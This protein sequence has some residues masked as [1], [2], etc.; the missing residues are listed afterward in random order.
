M[1]AAVVATGLVFAEGA[2]N[3]KLFNDP[4]SVMLKKRMPCSTTAVACDTLPDLDAMA[5]AR[6]LQ[7]ENGVDRCL[8]QQYFSG[9]CEG[10][11]LDVGAL[12]GIQHSNTFALHKSMGWRGIN[13]EVDTDNYEQLAR[14][15]RD[16]LAN[17][18]AAAC[19]E[20]EPV[21]FA[22]SDDKSAGGI[23]EF[24]SEAHRA[25]HWPG[26]TEYNAIPIK[27]TPLQSILDQTVGTKPFYFDLAT[28][29]VEGAEASALFGIDFDRISFGV[30]IVE[31]SEDADTNRQIEEL[32]RAKGYN[33]S[34]GKGECDA[35]N[36]MW[37]VH[38]NFRGIYQKMK[39]R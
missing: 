3:I 39:S 16:D 31:K 10:R 22:I 5:K 15:R 2:M 24:A 11:Y 9:V 18:H 33:E 4:Q 13:V 23:W 14:N 17:V 35:G 27:C 7:S 25:K 38:Q 26:M 21:H 28:I 12:D 19:S 37:F 1:K 36:S 32:L 30:I 29:H 34:H 6:L 20:R 8:I